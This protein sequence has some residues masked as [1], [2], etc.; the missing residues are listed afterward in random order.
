MPTLRPTRDE[1]REMARI[2]TPLVV[3]NVGLMLMG[4][5]DSLMLGRVSGAALAAGALGNVCFW[6]V[7]TIGF[8]LVM[9]IDPV[10][11]QGLGAAD[12]AAVARGMQRG[13]LL[14][15]LV[16]LVM[17][18]VLW[19]IPWVLPLLDQPAEVVPLAG[20]YARWSIP[21]LLPFF[22]FVAGKSFWQASH[23]PKPIL[24]GMV[25]GNVANALLN[26][27]FIF[28]HW[29]APAAGV[30]GSA[31]STSVAR[32]IMLA[33]ALA[34]GWRTLGPAVRPWDPA[35]FQ[36]E[37][38]KRLA[39]LGLPIGLAFFF[40]FN[41]FGIVTVLAGQMGTAPMAGHEV[42]LNL[43]SLTFQVPV[44]VAA[45][46][47]VMV[48]RAIGRGDGAAARRETV[49]GLAVGVGFMALAAIVFLTVPG[50]V[51]RA[52]T[53][54]VAVIAVAAGVIPIAGLFQVFDGTQAVTSS[55]LRGAGD[56]RVPMLLTLTGF[57]AIGLPLSAVLGVRLHWGVNGLWWGFVAGLA[58]VAFLHLTRIRRLLGRDIRRLDLEAARPG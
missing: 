17:T 20:A 23:D 32:W 25:V 22:L 35:S 47:G 2:A 9:G 12:H 48:G 37:P 50:A 27:M 11:A 55:V 49:A 1:L 56:T 40:E 8:G 18:L 6:F 38:L 30:V 19:P 51:A 44:G 58:A 26:W 10:I 5:V 28:G 21:G 53:T 7:S 34:A 14:A 13:V 41:A 43:A 46:T 31:I 33:A 57:W 54:D 39:L 45:A 15:C 52:Y 3:V 29:G 24:I 4:V 16:T 42:A 36:R